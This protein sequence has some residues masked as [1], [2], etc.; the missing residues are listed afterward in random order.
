MK[1]IKRTES[2][3]RET[4][5]GMVLIAAHVAG[6]PPQ[7]PPIEFVH[8]DQEIREIELGPTGSLYSFTVV[9]PGKDKPPYGLAMVDFE[10]GVRAFGRLLFDTQ[11]PAI[12]SRLRVMPLTLPDGT[13][14]YAFQ[15]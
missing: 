7:F 5:G 9:H 2:H 15:E 8:N 13:H 12:G 3:F 6:Q 4:A 1:I 10:P 11:P 14:D